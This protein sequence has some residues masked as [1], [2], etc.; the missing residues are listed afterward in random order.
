MYKVEAFIRVHRLEAVRDA[1]EEVDIIGL[2]VSDCRGTGR[3]KSTAH[4]FRG[5]QYSHSFE[6]RARIEVLTTESQVDS[7]VEAIQKAANTGEVGD[8]KIFVT[9]LETVVRIR[10]NERGES[11]LP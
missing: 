4:S 5:S 11:A 6:P 1:L 3:Q 10:T 2:T 7:A 9:K 8:G